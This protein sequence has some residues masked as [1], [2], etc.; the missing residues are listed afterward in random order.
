MCLI[1][2][3]AKQQKLEES[4]FAA[5]CVPVLA[6]LWPMPDRAIR[7]TLLKTSKYV[8]PLIP[9]A[10]FNKGMFDAMLAGFADSNAKYVLLC[11]FA[12][13]FCL[14]SISF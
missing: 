11:R 13:S 1:A 6:V 5:K 3:L 9:D 8:M 12:V 14:F 4:A 10:A 2:E 7:T